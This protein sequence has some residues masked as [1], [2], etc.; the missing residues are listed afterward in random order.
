M[1]ILSNFGSVIW[2][3]ILPAV[4]SI[5]E[6]RN[7]RRT[8]IFCSFTGRPLE[9]HM[10]TL[11]T[12]R[13]ISRR[14]YLIC[15]VYDTPDDVEASEE[16]IVQIDEEVEKKRTVG[17]FWDL[18][19]KP[20]NGVMPY[21]AAIR[22][23]DLAGEFGLVVDMVAYANRHA[24]IYVPQ[25]VRDQRKERKRLNSLEV[26]GIATPYQP[27]RCQYCGRKCDTY[28][29]LKRHFKGQHERERN[30]RISHLKHLKGGKKQR[31]MEKLAQKEDKYQ[32]IAS[33]LLVPKLGYGLAP[34]LRRAGVYVRTVEDRPQAA[35]A[36]LIKHMS[37]YINRGLETLILVSDDSDF[38]DILRLASMRNLQT[39]VIG[40]T[41]TL[42]RHADISFSWQEVASGRAQM[43]AAEAHRQWTD[44]AALIKERQDDLDQHDQNHAEFVT[45]RPNSDVS[46]FTSSESIEW[47]SDG[48]ED[49]EAFWEGDFDYEVEGFDNEDFSS[50]SKSVAKKSNKVYQ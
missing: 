4:N 9:V 26:Q 43:A 45:M 23:R 36:A 8:R 20:P 44:K 37:V 19:N 30:K 42:S 14:K 21:K 33:Q 16:S 15:S 35:D 38:T 22:L 7:N 11:S 18:D 5:S 28:F 13:I 46:A 47:E 29:K 48:D 27:Y 3:G 32:A 25:W 50:Q 40:D 10:E 39:I 49:S 17:V 2:G 1:A 6:I 24:F 34:E 41:M 12:R 31:Y